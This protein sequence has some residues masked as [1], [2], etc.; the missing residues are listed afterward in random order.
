M[1]ILASLLTLLCLNYLVYSFNINTLNTLNTQVINKL[2]KNKINYIEKN[3]IFDVEIFLSKESE[4]LNW[5]KID[6]KPIISS[7]FNFYNIEY[8]EM[9]SNIKYIKNEKIINHHM[10]LL[11]LEI[12]M[13]NNIIEMLVITPFYISNADY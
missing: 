10:N 8:R 5:S 9:A 13:M 3:N 11:I 2:I 6:F 12:N 1:N 4:Y 7:Y